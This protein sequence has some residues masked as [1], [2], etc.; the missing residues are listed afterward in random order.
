ME[1][2][3]YTKEVDNIA[4]GENGMCVI[5]TKSKSLS[6]ALPLK[7]SSLINPCIEFIPIIFPLSWLSL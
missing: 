2:M 1:L 6:P 3:T 5:R 4:K 7:T